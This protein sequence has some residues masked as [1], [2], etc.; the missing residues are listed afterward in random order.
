MLIEHP[1]PVCLELDIDVQLEV[2]AN[3]ARTC[4]LIRSLVSQ[5]LSEMSSGGDLM[6]TAVQ[7]D[8]GIELEVADT[9]GDVDRRAQSR[10][11]A[12]AA[13]GATL[14]WKNCPQGGASVT[15]M[16]PPPPSEQQFM[17]QSKAA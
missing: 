2:P 16:F 1:S 11:M 10:P 3:P 17:G 15:V 4:D 8:A 12:A 14:Q 6:I 9:G 13:I 5:S 7:T